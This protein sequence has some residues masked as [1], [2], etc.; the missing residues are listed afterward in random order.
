MAKD[1]EEG[2]KVSLE[3]FIIPQK[4]DAFC[5]AYAPCGAENYADEV[6]TDNRLREF[7][8][9]YVCSLGDPLSVYVD[10]LY[11]AGFS[12][13]VTMSGEPAIM[14]TRKC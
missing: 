12:L 4:I 14:A 2:A 8:K 13:T 7:F 10:R 1:K 11:K 6:F 5:N 3:D 9:A